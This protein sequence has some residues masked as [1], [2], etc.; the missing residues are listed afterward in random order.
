MLSENILKNPFKEAIKRNELQI[1]LWLCSTTPFLAEV[2]A[3]ADYD[4]LLVDGEHAPNTMQ[5]LYDQVQ[6]IDPYRSQAVVRPVEGTR[7]NIKQVLDIGAKTILIPMVESAAQVE[8]IYKS[9]CYSP[10]GY[11]G[12]GASIARVSRW[13]RFPNYMENVEDNLCLLVQVESREGLEHL[14]EITSVE[15]VDGVFFGP[16]DLST[17][18]GYLGDASAP[19]VKKTMEY[20]IKRVR[21]LGKAAGTLATD[22][23]MAKQFIE[24]G[25]TFVA[26]GVD[27]LLFNDALDARLRMFKK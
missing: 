27:V 25:A 23:A 21:E 17:D 3:T 1:G 26:V 7:A 24:W 13:N 16:A 6:A 14:D 5:D 12:V 8:E 20:G 2:A 4:W 22:P 19:E 18:M 10:K 9:M 11:R 15:G